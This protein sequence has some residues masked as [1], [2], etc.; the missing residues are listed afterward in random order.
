MT[1]K[2]EESKIISP[3]PHRLMVGWYTPG[4]A[5][6]MLEA[7]MMP[8]QR[9]TQDLQKAYANSYRRQADVLKETGEK[10]AKS[11]RDLLHSQGADDVLNAE[12][13]LATAMWDDALQRTQTWIEFTHDVQDCMTTLVR[14]SCDQED[15]S[16]AEAVAHGLKRGKS[17]TRHAA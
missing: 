16:T 14:H 15:R 5:S 17:A 13:Q 10:V 6:E 2:V 3:W 1:T 11:V 8:L 12:S 4:S 9:F 7:Q